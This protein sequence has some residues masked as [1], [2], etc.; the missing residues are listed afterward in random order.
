MAQAEASLARAKLNRAHAELG[1]SAKLI[2]CFLRHL[3]EDDA[4]AT[5]EAALFKRP[6]VIAYA[7]PGLSY[8][9]MRRRRG[10][11]EARLLCSGPG[12]LTAAMGITG[13]LD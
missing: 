7:M 4:M 6:M 11:A 2:L 10:L 8:R 1:L 13:N 3:S 5:L 9:L 12:R